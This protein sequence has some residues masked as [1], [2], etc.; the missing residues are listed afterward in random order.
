MTEDLSAVN[1]A[2]WLRKLE[3]LNPGK[4][5][6]GL[7]RITQVAQRMLPGSIADRILSVAGTNGKGSCICVAEQILLAADYRVGSYTSPHI[8]RFNERIRIQGESV[9]DAQLCAAFSVVENARQDSHL[10]YFE[11][12]T[13]A[14][15]YLFSQAQLDVALLEVGLGGRLDAV[16]IVDA[17]VAVVTSIALDHQGWLGDTREEIGREK[18]GIFRAGVSAI[19]GDPDPPGALLNHANAIGAPSQLLGEA[20][21]YEE[22][23]AEHWNWWTRT[24]PASARIDSLP[25]PSLPVVNAAIAL[26]AIH[27]LGLDVSRDHIE[28]G[29]RTAALAGRFQRINTPVPTVFDVAHNEASAAYLAAKLAAQSIGGK[30]LMICGILADKDVDRIVA[31]LV[32]LGDA[33]LVTDLEADR[34]TPALVL[35]EIVTNA[36]G[37]NVATCKSVPAAM[38]EAFQ[39]ATHNDLVVVFGSFYTVAAG[40]EYM[41][42]IAL[43]G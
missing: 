15:F 4:I 20:F 41:N 23:G 34:A 14:A 16:N 32:P 36:G 42:R 38:Q 25:T 40:L 31:P 24:G 11:F 17:D 33:W 13:L 6:L 2:Q 8:S 21:G 26:Q 30:I 12:T 18:A 27:Q 43:D 35:Q 19:C 37:R 39:Q 22:Q 9:S 28:A 10:T 29:L 1:I 5:E 7:D 3:R